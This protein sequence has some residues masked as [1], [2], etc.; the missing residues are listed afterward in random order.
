MRRRI[1]SAHLVI[2]SGTKVI[3][4]GDGRVGVVVH[5]PASPE[6]VYQVRFPAG[7]EQMFRR[8]ELTVFR[9]EQA[10][11]PLGADINSLYRFVAYRCIVGSRAYGLELS[12]SDVDRRG[13]YLP[14]AEFHWSL[15]GVP[16]Q[17]E[18]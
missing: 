9:H 14:P 5:T 8:D 10:D 3:A 18:N 16:E 4:R 15:A 1:Q 7:E 6:H 11:I 12:A 17:L 2:P 13:F